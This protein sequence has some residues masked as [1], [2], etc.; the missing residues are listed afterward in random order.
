MDIR[1][2]E[3]MGKETIAQLTDSDSADELP[4]SFKHF[5]LKGLTKVP[6]VIKNNKKASK[7]Y[8]IVSFF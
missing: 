7:R 4:E 5:N 1:D 8:A 6:S 3:N 2:Y